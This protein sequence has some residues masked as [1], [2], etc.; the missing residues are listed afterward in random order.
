MHLVSR[1]PTCPSDPAPNKASRLTSG[2]WTAAAAPLRLVSQLAAELA[3]QTASGR[4]AERLTLQPTVRERQGSFA[5][6]ID[7]VRVL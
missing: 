3:R 4:A 5:V 2:L 7:G 1:L 6:E